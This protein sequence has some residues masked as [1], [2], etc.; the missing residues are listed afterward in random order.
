MCCHPRLGS[1]CSPQPSHCHLSQLT[2]CMPL[3]AKR[4][5]QPPGGARNLLGPRQV[6]PSSLKFRIRV[7]VQKIQIIFLG[8]ED[9]NQCFGSHNLN[10]GFGSEDPNYYYFFCF[11]GSD[12]S[13]GS[14][15]HVLV[16]MRPNRTLSPTSFFLRWYRLIG[17]PLKVRLYICVN[18]VIAVF[19]AFCLFSFVSYTFI[20]HEFVR[21]CLC[22]MLTGSVRHE[23]FG[24]FQ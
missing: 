15:V 21:S 19:V 4:F 10:P 3:G 11:R 22:F 16:T 12:Q 1:S 20:K 5:S 18:N 6:Q 8:S 7:R 9:P 24:F 14:S 17:C 13:S 2:C 23:G